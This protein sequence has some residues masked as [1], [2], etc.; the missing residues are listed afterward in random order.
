M[1]ESA[2]VVDDISVRYG[3]SI[4]ALDDVSLR[5]RSG[6]A[7]ALLG[8]NGAGK[9]SLLRAVTG[10]L[11]IHRGR[12]IRGAITV[13]G[14]TVV[15]KPTQV[16]RS[17]LAQVME[18]RRLFTKLS[19]L[20]NIATGA[21]TLARSERKSA[22]SNAIAHFPMLA[23]RLSTPVGLLSGGQQQMVAIARAVA[24]KPKL[25]VLDEP[26][27][28]L[29]PVAIDGVKAVLAGLREE[30]LSMLLVEQNA[31]VAVEIT[32]YMYVLQRGRIRAEGESRQIADSGIL[33]D[34]YFAQRE[35]DLLKAGTTPATAHDGKRLPWMQ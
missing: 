15:G 22:I 10:L 29:A 3:T 17:G 34:L 19:V 5:V 14:R 13:F 33:T 26:S 20:E 21:A 7:V 2:L 31:A 12:L 23:E 35:E 8:P 9:T 18:G 27:L 24:S 4:R 30:G 11:P 32:D 25:L 28:G 6:Q 1:S 16:V